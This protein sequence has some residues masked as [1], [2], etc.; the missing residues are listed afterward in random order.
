MDGQSEAEWCQFEKSD[1]QTTITVELAP[2]LAMQS[3]KCGV[4]IQSY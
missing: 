4:D 3:I 1:T 2:R